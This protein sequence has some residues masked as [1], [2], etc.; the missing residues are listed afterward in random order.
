MHG[1]LRAAVGARVGM[2][3]A[4]QPVDADAHSGRQRSLAIALPRLSPGS[5]PTRP[6]NM[7]LTMTGAISSIARRLPSRRTNRRGDA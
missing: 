5:R 6:V 2:L 7:P 3:V 1:L 4:D